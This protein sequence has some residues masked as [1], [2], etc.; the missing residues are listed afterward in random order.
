MLLNVKEVQTILHVSESKAYGII[1]SLNQE[2]REQGFLTV[3]GR[4]PEQYLKKRFHLWEE[5]KEK[6]NVD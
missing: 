6:D 2:L 5:S 4:V 1:R 3:R